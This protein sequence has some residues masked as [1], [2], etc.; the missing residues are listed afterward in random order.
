[1]YDDAA[2]FLKK[3]CEQGHSLYLASARK[4]SDIFKDQVIKLGIS[5]IFSGIHCVS[6]QNAI[7]EKA[8]YIRLVGADAI[9]GDTEVELEAAKKT[10][11]A[12]YIVN[13]GFRSKRY[14]ESAR[15]SSCDSLVDMQFVVDK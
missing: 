8:E 9:V 3:L 15:V 11:I 2:P 12:C 4:R 5:E 13:R 1:M 6:P 10:G 7:S 14:W